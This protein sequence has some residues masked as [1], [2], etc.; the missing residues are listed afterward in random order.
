MAHR[1]QR[2]HVPHKG[3]ERNLRVAIATGVALG[4]LGAGLLYIGAEAFF[5][6]A[7]VLLLVAQGE[8]YQATRKAGHNPATA[9]GL[10]S[11]ALLLVGVFFKDES[12]AGIVLFLTLVFCFI[13]YK[14][15]ESKGDLISNIGITMLGVAYVPLLGSFVGLLANRPDGRGVTIVAIGLVALYDTG[16]YAA[17]RRFGRKALAPSVSPNKTL[18]G[19]AAASVAVVIASTLIAPQLGPWNTLQAGIL[20]CL[21]ALAAPLGDLFESLLKRD[22]GIKD[23]GTVIPGHGGALDRIDAMLFVM[24]VLYFSL[25]LFGY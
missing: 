8:F 12:A 1:A 23:M 16:A 13:W 3:G 11:G 18:E 6:L 2:H 17:G 22:L 19:A 24:P 14:A 25:I 20:G 4:G 9:L 21:I 7:F 5:G 15:M 10:V